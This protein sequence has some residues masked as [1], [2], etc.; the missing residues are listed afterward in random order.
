MLRPR[1]ARRRLERR[2]ARRRLDCRGPRLR[3]QSGQVNLSSAAPSR[4]VRLL[5][6]QLRQAL[7]RHRD[8]TQAPAARARIDTHATPPTPVTISRHAPTHASAHS[9]HCARAARVSRGARRNAH[10]FKYLLHLGGALRH[11]PCLRPHALRSPVR[12]V[13]APQLAYRVRIRLVAILN[14]VHPPQLARARHCHHRPASAPWASSR[15]PPLPPPAHRQRRMRVPRAPYRAPPAGGRS[16]PPSASWLV[17]QPARHER[18][19]VRAS[20]L[21]PGC[22]FDQLAARRSGRHHGAQVCQ[23]PGVLGSW[24]QALFAAKKR[25]VADRNLRANDED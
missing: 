18:L 25:V 24:R 14:V 4:L 13:H 20:S 5:C 19:G 2:R 17:E 12:R 11:R 10:L 21:V 1:L 23:R 16:K 6:E 9:A 15:S 7:L 3:P 8:D 22:S